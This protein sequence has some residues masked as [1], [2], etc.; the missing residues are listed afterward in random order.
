MSHLIYNLEMDIALYKAQL[1]AF[2]KVI[3]SP[4]FAQLPED[5]QASRLRSRGYLAGYLQD[6]LEDLQALEVAH[7]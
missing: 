5:Q 7:G 6:A 1:E 3:A 2:D 4:A